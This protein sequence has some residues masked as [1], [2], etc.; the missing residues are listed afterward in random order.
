MTADLIDRLHQGVWLDDEPQ[1]VERDA[2]RMSVKGWDIRVYHPDHPDVS[3]KVEEASYVLLDLRW[4]SRFAKRSFTNAKTFAQR[5]T[6]AY[7]E[8]PILLISNFFADQEFDIIEHEFSPV[9]ITGRIDKHLER[10][11]LA[12]L[13]SDKAKE[14]IVEKI[15]E[16]L[17]RM[18]DESSRLE[19]KPSLER[20]SRTELESIF[21]I[22]PAEYEKYTPE[23]RVGLAKQAWRLTSDFIDET[24][25]SS[26]ADWIV[27]TGNP[28]SIVRWGHVRDELSDDELK[29]IS[30]RYQSVPF[31]YSR[32]EHLS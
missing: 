13:R 4:R 25:Q 32:P 28:P 19:V 16:E 3:A 1:E 20:A 8:K 10:G 24:F 26:T 22:T 21:S 15:D 14:V 7:P 9:A 18:L 17:R 31:V 12:H 23:Q 2:H 30:S 5:L 11:A 27:I 29:A 6:A